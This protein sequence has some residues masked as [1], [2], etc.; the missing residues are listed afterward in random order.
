MA[1]T[2]SSVSYKVLSRLASRGEDVSGLF[3]PDIESVVLDEIKEFAYKIA[4]DT[5]LYRALQREFTS[6]VTTGK[7]ATLP[8]DILVETIPQKG[9]VFI[10]TKV[11]LPVPRQT[12]AKASFLDNTNYYHYSVVGNVL[13]FNDTTVTAVTATITA[14]FVPT[15][16]TSA[17]TDL[18]DRLEDA[19]IDFVAD[20]IAQ[21]KS[22]SSR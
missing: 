19:F 17:S 3:L 13:N 18:P 5:K 8:A 22:S 15:L 20:A 6:S 12:S 2:P 4:S 1:L 7:T 11:A 16:S 10:G 14:N 21:S 9:T